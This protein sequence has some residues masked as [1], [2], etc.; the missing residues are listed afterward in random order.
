MCEWVEATATA[1]YSM[2]YRTIVNVLLA[3]LHWCNYTSI[4]CENNEF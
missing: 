1:C 3:E 2:K 4:W